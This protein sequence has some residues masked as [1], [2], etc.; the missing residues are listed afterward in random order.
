MRLHELRVSNN[1]SQ[2]E[3]GKALDL[4][5]QRISLLEQGKSYPSSIEITK[6]AQ[7]FDVSADYILEISHKEKELVELRTLVRGPR[8]MALL[9]YYSKLNENMKKYMLEMVQAAGKY[10]EQE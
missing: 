4:T 6:Y 1:L 10:Q 7:Y 3:L 9:R 8:E 5:Q 2:K